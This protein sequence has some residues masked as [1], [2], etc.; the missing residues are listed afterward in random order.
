MRIMIISLDW[1]E[2]WQAF[3]SLLSDTDEKC[4][5]DIMMEGMVVERDVHVTRRTASTWGLKSTTPFTRAKYAAAWSVLPRDPREC[6]LWITVI[7]IFQWFLSGMISEREYML[8]Q[9]RNLRENNYV[10]AKRTVEN[11]MLKTSKRELT[12]SRGT[13]LQKK[14]SQIFSFRKWVRHCRKSCSICDR[15]VFA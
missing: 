12:Y 4:T 10:T 7:R 5:F 13:C 6:C 2:Q 14:K 1:F 3:E 8:T 9:T 11:I 15:W